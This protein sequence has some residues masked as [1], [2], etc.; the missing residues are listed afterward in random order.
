MFYCSE[1]VRIPPL[2]QGQLSVFL[3]SM[4]VF[5]PSNI[6][7]FNDIN[8]LFFP[9]SNL[10]NTILTLPL[11]TYRFP[12]LDPQF[13]DFKKALRAGLRSGRLKAPEASQTE[14]G[15]LNACQTENGRL[16]A[17]S[18]M[19]RPICLQGKTA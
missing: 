17:S 3:P 1:I 13:V 10:L 14:F 16:W 5:L 12:A 8:N 7:L 19:P 9:Y 2:K 18:R 4:S 15:R 11:K 6:I